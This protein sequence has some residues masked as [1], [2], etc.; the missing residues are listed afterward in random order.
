M[1]SL[2]PLSHY[3]HFPLCCFDHYE[4][5]FLKDNFLDFLLTLVLQSQDTITLFG[6]YT[7]VQL[8]SYFF[9]F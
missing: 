7:L 1:S 3:Q 2:P 6:H 5:I 9:H 4:Y 8:I